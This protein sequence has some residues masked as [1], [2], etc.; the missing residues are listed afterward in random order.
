MDN[1]LAVLL[2]G[3][4]TLLGTALVSIAYGAMREVLLEPG[5]TP[6]GKDRRNALIAAGLAVVVV[7]AIIA[8]GRSWWRSE[9]DEYARN[10]YE[11]PH[12]AT[13]F[14]NGRLFLD[15]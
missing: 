11:T 7:G 2:L 5:A 1:K 14:E 4:M 9:A 12:I 10:L 3:L 15:G 8:G 6:Q 13:R